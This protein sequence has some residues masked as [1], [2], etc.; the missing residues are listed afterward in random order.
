MVVLCFKC[1]L[2]ILKRSNDYIIYCIT[3]GWRFVKINVDWSIDKLK[4]IN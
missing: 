3:N 1:Y 2:N 4:I